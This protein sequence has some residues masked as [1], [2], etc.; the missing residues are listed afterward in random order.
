MMIELAQLKNLGSG[1][2]GRLNSIFRSN[3][4]L[5][6]SA[7]SDTESEQILD[8]FKTLSNLQKK[9]AVMHD[10]VENNL[11]AQPAIGRFRFVVMS[12]FSQLVQDGGIEGLDNLQTAINRA[13]KD[14]VRLIF[15]PTHLADADHLALVYSMSKRKLGIEDQLIFLG[16]AGNMQLRQSI[17]RFTRSANVI[18]NV[19]PRDAKHLQ[20]LRELADA[21]GLDKGQKKDL[22]SIGETFDAMK[23]R[24]AQAVKRIC[25]EGK[26]PMVVYIEGG[27]SY[28]G[29]LRSPLASYSKLIP[30]DD[31]AIIVP[32]RI[33]GTREL[34]PPGEDPKQLLRNEIYFPWL[35]HKITIRVGEPY[36]SSEVWKIWKARMESARQTAN[37]EKVE[38]NP[39]DWVMANIANLDPVF[40]KKS[41][42]IVYADLME[43]FAPERNRMGKVG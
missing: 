39:M 21:Y 20:D 19:T 22:Q 16:G 35:R 7:V 17:K 28:D 38:I 18:Y 23:E 33:Y 5:Q 26:N 10:I 31:S 15:T 27:R 14:H 6:A 13:R 4:K 30:R 42:L 24:S 8:P 12:W 41:D 34:N 25:V 36:F 43:S 3:G 2:G 29:Y 40:V 11:V 9:A 37:G 32:C 1:I